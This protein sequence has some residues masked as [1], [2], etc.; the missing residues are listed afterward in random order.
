MERNVFNELRPLSFCI[1]LNGFGEQGVRN[2]HDG[3][4]LPCP[5]VVFFVLE[6]GPPVVLKGFLLSL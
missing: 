4:G 6:K 5:Y 2:R 1:T 3:M